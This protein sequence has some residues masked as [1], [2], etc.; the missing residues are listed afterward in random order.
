MR[1]DVIQCK[2]CQ[3]LGH[4]ATNCNM[5]YRCVK[6]NDKHDPGRCSCPTDIQ[7]D[8]KKLFCANC[9]DYG[10]PASYRGCPKLIENKKRVL[11]LNR[12]KINKKN[13]G[14]LENPFINKS[15]VQPG[16]S[17]AQI[18]SQEFPNKENAI[19]KNTKVPNLTYVNINP[20]GNPRTP[21]DIF[22]E[23]RNNF[24]RLEKIVEENSIRINTISTLLERLLNLNNAQPNP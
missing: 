15:I 20:N 18:T 1:R 17:Y 8:K 16:I 5:P 14:K 9:N 13:N 22:L 11:E 2:N 24:N 21:K 19:N 10:H 4:A 7:L 12:N 23:M 6:C 3:R